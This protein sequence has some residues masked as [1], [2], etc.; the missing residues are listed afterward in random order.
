MARQGRVETKRRAE[1][2]IGSA[3]A[4]AWRNGAYLE[5]AEPEGETVFSDETVYGGGGSIMV[6]RDGGAI[7]YVPRNGGEYIQ[8]D[9]FGRRV[10][11]V[12]QG[13][14]DDKVIRDRSGRRTA[15]A[16]W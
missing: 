12:D 13:F 5:R 16:D 7:W 9:N 11:T 6:D 1:W 4:D 2:A 3:F 10:G 15:A 14:G 8:R